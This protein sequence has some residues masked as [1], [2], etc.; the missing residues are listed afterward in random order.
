MAQ[1]TIQAAQI[2][3]NEKQQRWNSG[4]STPADWQQV[5]VK[6]ETTANDGSSNGEDDMMLQLDS[7]LESNAESS[8]KSKAKQQEESDESCGE[9][10]DC[11]SDDE[12]SSDSESDEEE[13]KPKEE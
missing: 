4:A 7:N 8:K 9:S 13:L 3:A 2:V 1:Q 11:S 10:S 6:D 5:Q 12:S